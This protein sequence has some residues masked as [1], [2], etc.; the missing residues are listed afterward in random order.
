MQSVWDIQ[1][2]GQFIQES[3]V[4]FQAIDNA[5]QVSVDAI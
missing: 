4:V 1:L 3:G 5:A 2:V